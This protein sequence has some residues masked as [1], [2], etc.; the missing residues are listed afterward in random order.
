[1]D[2]GQNRAKHQ[3]P[4]LNQMRDQLFIWESNQRTVIQGED[5]R[6]A[7][8]DLNKLVLVHLQRCVLKRAPTSIV[9]EPHLNQMRDQLFIWES[10]QRTV[11]QGRKS[12]L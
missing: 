5:V 11:I 2:K 7:I 10:N 4:H 1:L 8:E 9:V 3:Q 6:I 12:S